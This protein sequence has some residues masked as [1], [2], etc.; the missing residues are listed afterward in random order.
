MWNTKPSLYLSS[1][2]ELFT[3][4]PGPN[5]FQTGIANCLLDVFVA[6]L[7]PVPQSPSSFLSELLW[8]WHFVSP[9]LFQERGGGGGGGKVGW[10]FIDHMSLTTTGGFVRGCAWAGGGMNLFHTAYHIS[11]YILRAFH[12]QPPPSPPTLSQAVCTVFVLSHILRHFQ[13]RVIFNVV[14]CSVNIA[15]QLQ[16]LAFSGI[17]HR[18]YLEVFLQS[19]GRL[20]CPTASL[21]VWR[22]LIITPDLGMN[23]ET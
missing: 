16:H 10:D 20:L 1:Q 14:C 9:Q 2:K 13:R 18:I 22:L 12:V 11:N 4:I 19:E 23:D 7:S 8:L 17:F 21:S 15:Q 6:F 3:V 5:F